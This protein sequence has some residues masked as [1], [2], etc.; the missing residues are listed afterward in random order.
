MTTLLYHHPVCEEHDTGSGH[1]E[2]PARLAAILDAL[3]TPE[4]A[5]LEW[6]QAPEASMEQITRVHPREYV[7]RILAA[8]P[9]Q[10]HRALDPDTLLSPRSGEAA[11][12][13]AG[14]VCAAVDALMGREADNA[15]CAI[16]PPG[17][18]AEPT[19]AMGFCLF[20]NVAIGA[21]H[22]RAAH[23]LERVAIVDFDVHHG[24]GTQS[25][26]RDQPEYLY[27]SS[28]QSPLYPG[29][30][31]RSERGAGNIVNIPLA[32]HSGSEELR[33][34]WSEHME[35]ALRSFRPDFIFISAG[36]DGHRSDPLAGLDFTEEDY[37]WITRQI[38][39]LAR[40]YCQGRVVSTL[41]G[42]YNL[43]ALAAS[44]AAH[45]RTLMEG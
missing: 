31:Q 30:G 11:L 32:P 19:T 13:A 9:Q 38:L 3:R 14:A 17:H 39:I 29:T 15:F 12:R 36:F 2:S 35:G 44:A 6:R 24:N 5:A 28:H 45:V 27:I 10:G 20:N 1:P 42:G 37:G 22:V 40:E 18:H 23:H 16:R 21:A 34:A 26:V 7:E 8:V 25:I 4:F 33:Q 43:Q 41:E